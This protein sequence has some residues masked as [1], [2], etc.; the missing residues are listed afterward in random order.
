[1]DALDPAL[2]VGSS[3]EGLPVAKALQAELDQ[4]CEPTVW[5]QNIFEAGGTVISDLLA[6]AQSSDFAV[7]VLTPDDTIITR[8]EK[9]AVARDNVIFELGLFLGALGPRRVFIIYPRNTDLHMPSDLAGVTVL[10]YKSDRADGNL[11]AALGPAA[12]EIQGRI[13]SEKLREDRLLPPQVSAAST[14]SAARRAMTIAEERQE[15]QRELDAISTSAT[16]QGWTIK[17]R[18]ATAFRL[19]SRNGQRYSFSIGSPAGTRDR[20]RSFAAQLQAAGLRLS[21]T[22]L[23]P[24]N[25]PTS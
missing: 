25:E 15:L 1:M 10:K 6:A 20:L 9:R 16:A 14:P 13:R 19:V 3:S 24:V 8:G 5:S 21:Q 22:V 17:T 4:D 18:S 12:T 2:F 7:L 23:L 11:R